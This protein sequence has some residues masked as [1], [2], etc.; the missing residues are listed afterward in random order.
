ME[1]W[2][3]NLILRDRATLEKHQ[4]AERRR[5]FEACLETWRPYAERLARAEARPQ[6]GWEG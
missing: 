5:R 3:L 2:K 6:H 1:P 4:E